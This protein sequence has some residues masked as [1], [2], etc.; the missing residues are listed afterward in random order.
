MCKTTFVP[1]ARSQLTDGDAVVPIINAVQ[2]KFDLIV[3]TQ[4]WHP[5]DHA[6]FAANHEGRAIGQLININ[7]KPQV[8][9]PVHCVQNTHGAALHAD[10]DQSRMA[11]IFR[12]GQNPRS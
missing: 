7:G 9:W 3:A 4:D 6:S 5:P 2:P 12:K 8:L 10:L 11:Q 1:A